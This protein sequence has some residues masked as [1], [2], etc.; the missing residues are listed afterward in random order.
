MS[1]KAE[2]VKQGDEKPV[3]ILGRIFS[4]RLRRSLAEFFNEVGELTAFTG[5]FFK[6]AATPPYELNEF[7]K[8]CFWIGNMSLPLVGITAFI[9]GL[10]FTMQSRPTLAQFGAESWLP[11]MVS[12]A[13]IREIAP[14]ITALICAGKVGS[15]IGAELAS[16][17]VTEQIDAMEV[18]GN[19]PFKYVVVTRVMACFLMVPLLVIFADSIAMMGSW[20]GVNITGNVSFN[21]FFASVFNSL[22][23]V[24]VFPAFVK[25]FFFGLAIGVISCYKGYN[26]N[27]G[28]EGVGKAANSAVVVAS[29][30]IFII[31]MIAVQVA[32]FF[33]K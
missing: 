8:Q 22:D 23:F 29:L 4:G 10:V 26:A 12:I 7:I 13:M 3:G 1:E 25:T 19:R 16:M 6:E 17:R 18:S 11:A 14:V 24:D 15:G 32:D 33:M 9:M 30:M 28:T 27:T 21:L 2:A 20:A 31:D 5:K